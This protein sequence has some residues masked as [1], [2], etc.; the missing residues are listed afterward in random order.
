MHVNTP[1]RTWRTALGGG[2]GGWHKASVSIC[3]PLAAPIGLSPPH[4]L[5]LCGPERVSVV[6]TE[7]PDDLSCLTTPGVGCPRRGGG[8]G[9]GD[10]PPSIFHVVKQAQGQGCHKGAVRVPPVGTSGRTQR[11]G[12]GVEQYHCL[13]C[14]SCVSYGCASSAASPT[15]PHTCPAFKQGWG[16]AGALA[17][18]ARPGRHHDSQLQQLGS[19]WH[20]MC[21][22]D[23][24]QY[25]SGNSVHV[26]YVHQMLQG[27]M[28]GL[29]STYAAPPT[30]GSS[31]G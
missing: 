11:S 9:G 7:P 15:R 26:V 5:T 14:L 6:P 2:G 24:M 29:H 8:G 3:L 17:S 25:T 10:P 1:T 18:R 19:V 12:L 31:V 4:I 13:R 22:A 21:T 27:T 30:L 23:L 16:G 28:H 20:A